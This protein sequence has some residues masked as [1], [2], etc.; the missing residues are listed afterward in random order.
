MERFKTY[1][2]NEEKSHLGQRVGNVLTAVQELQN[3]IGGMGIRQTSR[4]CQEIVNQLRKILHGSWTAKQT[5]HL[6]D[7]Q[8][9]AVAL[10]KTIDEKGD[11]PGTH[12]VDF[13]R[14]GQ[15]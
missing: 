3:D 9:I 6:K 11:D 13:P 12:S 1:L 5:P 10:M 4:S 8:K 14:T 7:V 15:D 2:L